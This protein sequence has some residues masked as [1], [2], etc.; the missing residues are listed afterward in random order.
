VFSI[1]GFCLSIPQQ[2]SRRERQRISR[3]CWTLVVTGVVTGSICA[4]QNS[5]VPPEFIQASQAMR[6]GNLEDAAAGFAAAA[7]R[8][9]SFAEAHFNLGLADEELGRY[10]EAI[11]SLREALKLKPHLR[12]ANL[13]LGIAEFRL[14][15]LD[16]AAAAVL[17]EAAADPKDP[18]P[19]MWLGVVRLAQ[20]RPEEAAQA[21]DRADK[22]KP[23]DPDILYHRGRAHLLVSKDSY[24]EMFKIDPNSWRVHR[25]LGQA[26]S[27]ADHHTEAITEF[28]SAI[29]LA[30]REPGLHEELGS[31]YLAVNKIA[32]GEAALRQELQINPNNVLATYKLGVIMVDQGDGAKGKELI[33]AAERAK[34]GMVHMDY[35]LGRAEMLLG[36]DENAARQFQLAIKT[37]SDPEVVTQ[38]WYQLGT[39]YRRLHRMDDARSAMATYQQLKDADAKRSQQQRDL[40]RA[41][42]PND[43]AAKTLDE[44][45]QQQ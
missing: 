25:V 45:H 18:N 20:D 10:D 28:E 30:P 36:E 32:E 34:P 12:G 2:F 21:L 16:D 41:T 9:P 24:A 6:A 5:A 35:N 44:Q 27:E 15:H 7:K 1:L 37:D 40:L 17:K 38:A 39:A 31:E 23:G 29:K 13:F 14:N 42:H 4:A 22:L 11:A 19:W 33:Q 26:D 43:A 8:Q 3:I